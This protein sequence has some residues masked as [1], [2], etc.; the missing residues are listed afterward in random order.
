MK[1]VVLSVGPIFREYA[2]GGSQHALR[3]LV[4]G[5]AKK[6]HEITILCTKRRDNNKPF[7][8][9]K[10]VKVFPILPFKETYPDP[11]RTHP[12][13]LVEVIKSIQKHIL[14]DTDL[15]YSHDSQSNLF[16]YLID[17]IPF[18]SSARDFVYPET[19]INLLNFKGDYLIV[20]SAYMKACVTSVL[21]V[22]IKRISERIKI[23]PNGYDL[24]IFKKT[25]PSKIFDFINLNRRKNFTP[26]LF[27]HRPEEN[28]GIFLALEAVQKL[29]KEGFKDI[30]L[31]VPLYIDLKLNTQLDSFYF[32]IKRRIKSLRIQNQI[33]F[34]RWIPAKLMPQYYSFGKITWAIGSFVES[35]G[36]VPLESVLCGTPAIISK[37]GAFRTELPDS[38]FLKVDF[39]DI[40]EL[41]KLTIKVLDN[42]Y[43]LEKAYNFVHSKYNSEK[44]IDGYEKIFLSAKKKG[45]L[46]FRNKFE[47]KAHKIAPWC[48]LSRR[49]IYNDY[50]QKYFKVPK[51]EK[52]LKE[53]ELIDRSTCKKNKITKEELKSW[54]SYGFLVEV[55]EDM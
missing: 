19:V 28:K 20:S 24:S 4:L 29:L 11:Y 10:N 12:F 32:K 5:L 42:E 18:V 44:M 16:T 38:I 53:N 48:Y 25:K 52:I 55:Y 35:F 13:K 45:K 21:G 2:H 1:I 31:L 9:H 41:V 50:L 15:I 30:K 6:G 7:K 43:N 23:V 39:G 36:N 27:P 54:V 33:V 22:P 46:M 3:T 34:H 51:L 14:Q 8:L 37:V 49:G 47:P 17:D 40:D 26:I